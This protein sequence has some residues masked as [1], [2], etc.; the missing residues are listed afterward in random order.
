MSGQQDRQLCKGGNVVHN[1]CIVTSADLWSM[2]IIDSKV[3]DNDYE[4]KGPMFHNKYFMKL[5]HTVM[6][7]LEELL[8][9][10]NRIE[11]DRECLA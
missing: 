11:Y 4:L 2:R 3:N 1:I 9:L 5:D 7:C 10:R 6:D 8:V